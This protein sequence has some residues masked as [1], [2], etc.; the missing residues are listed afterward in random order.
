MPARSRAHIRS[1]PV[2]QATRSGM[3]MIDPASEQAG[4][5]IAIYELG[6]SSFDSLNCLARFSSVRRLKECHPVKLIRNAI[7]RCVEPML[8]GTQGRKSPVVR[9]SFRS[10]NSYDV[11]LA[12]LPR[13]F[14]AQ[15]GHP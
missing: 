5:Q 7:V 15:L 8:G 4:P 11:H 3:L 12:F 10:S 14:S 13:V 2:K 9:L 1:R 6:T